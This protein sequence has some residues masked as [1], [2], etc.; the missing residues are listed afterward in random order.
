PRV[1]RVRPARAPARR[2]RAARDRRADRRRSLLVRGG[3]P[4]AGG[5]SLARGAPREAALLRGDQRA[6]DIAGAAAVGM[7]TCQ[8]L[9]FNAD[10]DPAV[11]PDFQA[12]T[13]MDV[14]TVVRR[15]AEG[16][17]RLAKLKTRG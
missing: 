7:R 10:E 5:P 14:A 2:P 3:G 8:A 11:E 4:E 1:E 13:Q 17:P 9:W 6:T 15:L 16:R 12:F